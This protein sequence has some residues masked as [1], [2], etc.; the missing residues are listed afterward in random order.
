M[1]PPARDFNQAGQAGRKFAGD[2]HPPVTAGP[3][4]LPACPSRHRT[5]PALPP[6]LGHPLP[7][8]GALPVFALPGQF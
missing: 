3:E 7:S 8:G 5:T 2:G 1:W 6:N 4:S